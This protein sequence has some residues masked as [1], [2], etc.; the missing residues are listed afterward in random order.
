MPATLIAMMM[1]TDL[2]FADFIV[3]T[4]FSPDRLVILL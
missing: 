2:Q 1:R 3:A 4:T